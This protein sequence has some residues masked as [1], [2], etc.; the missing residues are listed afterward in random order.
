MRP[1]L[2]A[3]T[4]NIRALWGEDVKKN[5][6]KGCFRPFLTIFFTPS[7]IRPVLEAKTPNIGALCGEDVKNNVKKVCFRP[8][9]MIFFLTPSPNA[10]NFGG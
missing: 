7:P 6:K 3:K 4:P 8:F 10:A 9:L 5:V 1:V 2:E